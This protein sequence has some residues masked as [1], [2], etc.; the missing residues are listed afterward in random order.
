MLHL[1]LT[2]YRT[3]PSRLSRHLLQL[4]LSSSIHH[5]HDIDPAV[6]TIMNHGVAMLP[7]RLLSS[8]NAE[9]LRVHVLDR[10]DR[11]TSDEEIPLSSAENRWSFR[12]GEYYY[13]VTLYCCRC[14]SYIFLIVGSACVG[15]LDGWVVVF[16]LLQCI[17]I[18]ASIVRKSDRHAYFSCFVNISASIKV[19]YRIKTITHPQRGDYIKS[20]V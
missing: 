15:L 20:I 19:I 6:D 12:I 8:A 3:I 11:L 17:P 1:I 5:H 7:Y 9:A 13:I 14:C 2:L 16:K 4:N 18:I 10:N